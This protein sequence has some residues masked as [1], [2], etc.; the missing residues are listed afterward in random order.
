MPAATSSP[1][2]PEHEA[3]DAAEVLLLD[4]GRV[5]IDID[6]DRCFEAWADAAALAGTATTAA[7]LRERF[8]VDPSFEA[9]ERGELSC[10]DF[11]AALADRLDL[12]LDGDAMHSGWNALFGPDVP[13]MIE[14]LERITA[15]REVHVLTNTNASH[16]SYVRRRH[17]TLLAH[18]S[19]VVASHELGLRKPEP[20]IY[21][22]VAR[23]LAR[24]PSRILFLDDSEA[25]VAGAR[26]RGLTALHVRDPR[27]TL[28]MLDAM[29]DRWGDAER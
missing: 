28:S 10:E 3:F 12:P 29:I 8:T 27:A 24:E 25:N 13:G 4:L 6:F 7:R 15:H 2:S 1:S 26:A 23:T 16:A 11:L 5:L 20:G 22:H 21:D 14:R 18:A 19:S 17:G 9:H